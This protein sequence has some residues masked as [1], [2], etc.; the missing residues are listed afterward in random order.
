MADIRS[1]DWA[2]VRM[3]ANVFD[4]ETVGEFRT[5]MAHGAVFPPLILWDKVIVDGNHRFPAAK[6]LKRKT[7][8]VF[9]VNFNSVDI[10]RAF[11]AAVNMTN[12]RRLAVDEAAGIALTMLGQGMTPDSVAREI[13]R[14]RTFV[15][16]VQRRNEFAARAEALPEIARIMR[17]KPLPVTTRERLAQVKHEPVFAEAVK[18]AADV[19]A[20]PKV[21][22][23]IV[24]AAASGKS[25]A[26]A[27]TAIRAKRAE[28]APQGP[29]PQ[30]VIIPESVRS[31]RRSMG[32]MLKFRANPPAL[33]D[34]ASGEAQEKA[35]GQWAQLRDLATE[36]LKLYGA[37]A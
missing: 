33:L 4:S 21:A 16:S 20:T 13:G 1:A 7:I 8:A 19:R 36:M 11:A 23:E 15:Q 3:G 28:L 31:C 17:E 6:G 5:H 2:Q 14:S 34:K 26:D 25:D 30:R 12:G 29:S 9:T 32:L 22:A 37:E 24:E 10:A 27:I 35:A 18:L